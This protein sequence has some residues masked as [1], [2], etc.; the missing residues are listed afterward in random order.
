MNINFEISKGGTT[1]ITLTEHSIKR[2]KPSSISETR[3][4]LRNSKV[5]NDITIS[6][7]INAEILGAEMREVDDTRKIA[8]FAVIPEFEDCY[9]DISYKFADTTGK[10]VAEENLDDTY[11][12]EYE[13]MFCNYKG[14][15]EFAATFREKSKGGTLV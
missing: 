5:T 8:D 4:N 2:F 13:E 6:G 1:E 7:V 11:V 10:I 3:P 15:G 9:K 14:V 12:V